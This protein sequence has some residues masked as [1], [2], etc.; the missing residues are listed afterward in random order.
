MD[1]LERRFESVPPLPWLADHYL[2]ELERRP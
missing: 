1:S 2:I